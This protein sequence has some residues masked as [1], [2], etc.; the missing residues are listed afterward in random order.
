M[1]HLLLYFDIYSRKTHLLLYIDDPSG[2][3]IKLIN[4]TK[5]VAGE[6]GDP[7]PA[8]GACDR[9]SSAFEQKARAHTNIVT[10]DNKNTFARLYSV[11]LT[12]FLTVLTCLNLARCLSSFRAQQVR[13]LVNARR[14]KSS[15]VQNITELGLFGEI[16]QTICDRKNSSTPTFGAN[17]V[18]LFFYCFVAIFV[19]C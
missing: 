9:V 13:R 10:S 19:T 7:L 3:M 4:W 11:F 6:L 14:M 1:T 18:V 2:Q 17:V 8:A 5:T 16:P 12:Y 15:S